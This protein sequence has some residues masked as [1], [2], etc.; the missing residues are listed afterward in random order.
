MTA[1]EKLRAL[2]EEGERVSSESGMPGLK[3][4]NSHHD[5][6]PLIADVIVAAEGVTFFG[7]EAHRFNEWH[8]SRLVLALAALDA[9]LGDET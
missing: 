8:G 5:L 9:A 1:S 6:L 2:H 7:Q 4:L 3:Y